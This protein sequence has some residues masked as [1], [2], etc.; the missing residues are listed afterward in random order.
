MNKLILAVQKYKRI[1][2]NGVFESGFIM[3][4]E[5]TVIKTNR[6]IKIEKLFDRYKFYMDGT[7]Q[8]VKEDRLREIFD[9]LV[10]KKITKS[11]VY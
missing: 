8:V 3:N 1:K 10:T 5:K 11:S 2:L 7:W 9:N 4:G 6:V